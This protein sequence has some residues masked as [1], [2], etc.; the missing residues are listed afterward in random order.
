M[1]SFSRT[2]LRLARKMVVCVLIA[3]TPLTTEAEGLLAWRDARSM[4]QLV[5][6]LDHWLDAN[7]S[8]A[9]NANAPQI[10]WIDRHSL[11]LLSGSQHAG[12]GGNPRGRYDPD[13]A[14]IYLVRPWDRRDPRDVSVLLHE[15]IHHRQA[16]AGYFY[17][18]GAQEL[19]AYRT[20]QKWLAE[21]GL[22]L[23]V[24]WIAVVLE[25]G[26][27]PRDFHPD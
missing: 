8:L 3:V 18:P 14:A 1:L 22:E 21:L 5:A 7:T 26:C 9:R 27:S 2:S 13:S 16:V 15:M 17:C 24:N 12:Y 25:S 10:S 19:P 23:D 6:H 20:Q 4:T 11:A